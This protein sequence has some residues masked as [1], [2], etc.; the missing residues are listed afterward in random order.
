MPPT[1]LEKR[2]A[3][4]NKVDAAR[5]KKIYGIDPEKLKT[6]YDLVLD[7]S[8]L[9]KEQAAKKLFDFVQPRLKAFK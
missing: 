1:E 6:R 2:I 7:N 5:Y 4:R 9:T 8:K 3:E